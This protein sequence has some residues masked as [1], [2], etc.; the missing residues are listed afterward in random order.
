VNCTSSK[1]LVAHIFDMQRSYYHFNMNT[2]DNSEEGSFIG[3]AKKT[4]ADTSNKTPSKVSDGT[5]GIRQWSPE[6]ESL[7]KSIAVQFSLLRGKVGDDI[8]TEM[9]ST[10]RH[11]SFPFKLFLEKIKNVKNCTEISNKV[12]QDARRKKSFSKRK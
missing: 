9:I 7:V 10:L 5:E 2:H 4:I 8:V 11:T 6:E 3:S 12:I 1:L